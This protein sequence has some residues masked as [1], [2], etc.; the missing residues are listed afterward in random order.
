MVTYW[1]R[2]S[3]GGVRNSWC[4]MRAGKSWLRL[5]GVLEVEY[6]GQRHTQETPKL[7]T[8]APGRMTCCSLDSKDAGFWDG[9][10]RCYCPS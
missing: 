5:A 2:D 4:R 8:R 10:G 3:G 1:D 7:L 6:Q 9:A